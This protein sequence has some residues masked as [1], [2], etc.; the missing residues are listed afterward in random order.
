MQQSGGWR[1][2]KTAG[3]FSATTACGCRRAG[4]APRADRDDRAGKAGRCKGRAGGGRGREERRSR[5][6][7]QQA[8]LVAL[9]CLEQRVYVMIHEL[10]LN[11]SAA[12]GLVADEV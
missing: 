11:Q 5:D 12:V 10:L 1:R 3:S 8:A 6:G 4:A 7:F 2:R 9:A